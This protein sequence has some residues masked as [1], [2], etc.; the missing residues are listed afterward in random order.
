MEL[1]CTLSQEFQ[2]SMSL[3]SHGATTISKKHKS[4]ASRSKSSL[5]RQLR[6]RRKRKSYRP[7]FEQLEDRRMLAIITPISFTA[8]A[9]EVNHLT[10][11]ADADWLTYNEDVPHVTYYL[12]AFNPEFLKSLKIS[13]T[14][15]EN[16]HLTEVLT[17]GEIEGIV[18]GIVAGLIE[19]E[20]A[21]PLGVGAAVGEVELDITADVT[22]ELT[23]DGLL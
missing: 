19:L 21:A 12:G 13:F 5:A 10:L 22:A 6:L 18:E 7:L 23:S 20:I 4:V 8:G 16:N 17:T 11:T 1:G 15:G 2:F 9:Q 14:G 3:S